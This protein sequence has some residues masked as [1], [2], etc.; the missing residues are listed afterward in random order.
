MTHKISKIIALCCCLLLAGPA[1]A[2]EVD[3]PPVAIDWPEA[4]APLYTEHQAAHVVRSTMAITTSEGATYL[5]DVPLFETP[6]GELNCYDIAAAAPFFAPPAETA[7]L[8]M[9][10]LVQDELAALGVTLVTAEAQAPVVDEALLLDM[11]SGAMVSYALPMMFE[12]PYVYLVAVA[13]APEGAR[14]WVC[15][16]QVLLGSYFAKAPW[17]AMLA[18]ADTPL[19]EA[20]SALIDGAKAARMEGVIGTVTVTASDSINI[21]ARGSADSE[22]IA[23]ARAGQTFDTLGQETPGGWYAVLL[24]SGETGYVSPKLVS[25]QEK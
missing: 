17:D 23:K 24:P 20:I 7:A 15:A 14:L 2:E 13:E 1:M 8:A 3:G 6:G 18:Q 9:G 11:S 10:R 4:I 22:A 12:G 19:K 5:V 16:D 25:F 21:R